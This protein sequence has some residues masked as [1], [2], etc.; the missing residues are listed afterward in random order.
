M[1]NKSTYVLLTE[2]H[3]GVFL[4]RYKY[5]E[6]KKVLDRKNYLYINTALRTPAEAR[7]WI[8]DKSLDEIMVVGEKNI[9]ERDIPINKMV[10]H[11]IQRYIVYSDNNIVGFFKCKDFDGWCYSHKYDSWGI[12]EF[13]SWTS[14]ETR[15]RY[16]VEN[17]KIKVYSGLIYSE[18]DYYWNDK[19]EF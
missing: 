14:A 5:L 3:C 19:E 18:N 17:Y 6:N 16:L 4:S 8:V 15:F 12:E 7:A 11:T 9:Q 2:T 10:R 1:N 13:D